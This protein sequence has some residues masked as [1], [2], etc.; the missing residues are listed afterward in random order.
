VDVRPTNGNFIVT[1]KDLANTAVQ[2]GQ[3]LTAGSLIGT[4]RPA[5]DPK[6]FIG[7]HVTLVN[8][9]FYKAFRQ[10]TKAQAQQNR[11]GTVNTRKMFIDPLGAG[12]PIKCP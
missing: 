5:G 10:E 7:L 11:L 12:S 4:V 1:Y 3:Q 6:N 2:V 9:E 8:P